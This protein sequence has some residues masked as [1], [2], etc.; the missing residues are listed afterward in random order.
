MS[1]EMN[2]SIVV[3]IAFAYQGTQYIWDGDDP[4]QRFD[5][6]GFTI[7]LMKSVGKLPRRGDWTAHQLMLLFLGD[8]IPA[9]DIRGGCLIWYGNEKKATH[10]EM[11]ISQELSIG[12]SGGGAAN[13]T[14]EEAIRRNAYVKI[15]PIRFRDVIMFA[16]PFKKGHHV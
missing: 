10:V 13:L 16:D 5:C 11:S 15:R 3:Q 4:I 12:A 6:S 7:E 8:S 2:R 14:R 1:E 9:E